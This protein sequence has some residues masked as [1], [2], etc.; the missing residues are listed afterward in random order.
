MGLGARANFLHIIDFG[1]V[2]YYVGAVMCRRVDKSVFSSRAHRCER[3]N[4][5]PRRTQNSSLSRN[6][7]LCKHASAQQVRHNTL[8]QR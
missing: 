6:I 5:V 4:Q 7:A 3:P 1:L 8:L 2:R